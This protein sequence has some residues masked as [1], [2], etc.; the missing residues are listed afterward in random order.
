MALKIAIVASG[1]GT[2][3]QAMFDR[4]KEGRLDA[5]VVLVVSNRPGARVLDRARAFGAP[6][7]ELDHKAFPDRET[8]DAALAETI[9]ASGAELVVLA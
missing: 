2:N 6:V 8:F 4:I 5:E 7:A 9:A 3:A 1:S